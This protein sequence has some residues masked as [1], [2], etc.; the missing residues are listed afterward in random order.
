MDQRPESFPESEIEPE[1]H[2]AAPADVASAARSC[3][4]ILLAFAVLLL[5]ICVFLG[6]RIIS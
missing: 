5:L 4:V 1:Q 2:A 3:T 6:V